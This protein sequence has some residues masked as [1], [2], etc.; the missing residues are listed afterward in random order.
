MLRASLGWQLSRLD[1]VLLPLA[2]SG[3]RQLASVFS[4]PVLRLG[5]ASLHPPT[6]PLPWP[7]RSWRR[8]TPRSGS[9]AW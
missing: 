8:G 7:V 5:S 6:A 9:W 3:N 1:A 2:N 4:L